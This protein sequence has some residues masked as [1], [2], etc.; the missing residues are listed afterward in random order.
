M[1]NWTWK[2]VTLILLFIL[3]ASGLYADFRA[4]YYEPA[5]RGVIHQTIPNISTTDA[6]YDAGQY[7]MYE[8]ALA[9][10][11]GKDTLELYCSTCHTPGFVPMQPPL[12]A[13]TWAA[14]V[15]K[16]RKVMGASI[17][18]DDARK[19]IAYLSSHYTPETRKH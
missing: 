8:P 15:E 12:P 1:R 3:A 2:I 11:E 7:P 17:P 18:D 13:E 14:E 16:M 9:D 19:I 6:T 10:G 4:G 5:T